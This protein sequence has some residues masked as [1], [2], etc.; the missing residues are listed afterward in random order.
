MSSVR[1]VEEKRMKLDRREK[2]VVVDTTRKE[3]HIVP[4]L[5]R[6]LSGFS[7]HTRCHQWSPPLQSKVTPLMFQ[8]HLH[9][10]SKLVLSVHCDRHW[11]IV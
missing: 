5:S 7:K 6:Q 4:N 9:F 8:Q 1:K 11:H 2:E 10:I 3:L